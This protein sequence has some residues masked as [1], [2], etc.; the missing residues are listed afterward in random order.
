MQNKT[1]QRGFTLIE[2]LVVMVVLGL[3]MAIGIP[4]FLSWL[5]NKRINAAARDLHGAIVT[6]KGQASKCNR[7]CNL[8]FNQVIGGTTYAY[9]LFVDCDGD[10][11]Y[12]A[13]EQIVIRQQWPQG[14]WL[15]ATTLPTNDD[16]LPSISFKPNSIPTGNGG[17]LANGTATLTN[18]DGRNVA[19][20]VNR[21]GNVRIQ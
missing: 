7:N 4:S 21:S 3:L 9:V 11:E 8:V 1:G 16:G 18:T 14:V 12:D 15:S 19:I 2:I 17:G 6:A 10:S 13:G 20:V 5:P